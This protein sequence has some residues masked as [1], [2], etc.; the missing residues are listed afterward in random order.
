MEQLP[1]EQ[2]PSSKIRRNSSYHVPGIPRY[3]LR[4]YR[5]SEVIQMAFTPNL[6]WWWSITFSASCGVPILDM[7]Q[8][9]IVPFFC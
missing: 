7:V 9:E 6:K 5:V 2:K 8:I 1:V 4:S 3:S